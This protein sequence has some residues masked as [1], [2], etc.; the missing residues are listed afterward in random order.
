MLPLIDID[1]EAERGGRVEGPEMRGGAFQ[2]GVD[3][4]VCWGVGPKL[5]DAFAEDA[6]AY[7]I[8]GGGGVGELDYAEG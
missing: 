3:I 5:V 7:E 2:R 4:W 1:V 6:S 8:F